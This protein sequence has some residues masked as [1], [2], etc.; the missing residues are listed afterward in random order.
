MILLL[1]SFQVWL[2]FHT[3]IT[4]GQKEAMFIL[5]VLTFEQLMDGPDISSETEM[6]TSPAPRRLERELA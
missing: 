3:C 6:T 1:E 4:S 5:N 2:L